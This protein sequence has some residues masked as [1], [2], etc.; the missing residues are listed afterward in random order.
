L[1]EQAIE[2]RSPN[3]VYAKTYEQFVPELAGD[4]R[5][6]AIVARMNFASLAE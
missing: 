4:A 1:Y 2:G 3:M 5:C 6:Q